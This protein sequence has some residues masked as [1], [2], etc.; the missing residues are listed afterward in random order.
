MGTRARSGTGAGARRILCSGC[1]S[2]CQRYVVSTAQP[3]FGQSRQTGSRPCADSADPN[4]QY[5]WPPQDPSR[6]PNPP[7][8]R[9][10]NAFIY[11]DGLNPNLRP[12]NGRRRQVQSEQRHEGADGWV[13]EDASGSGS[14]RGS[15]PER[16]LSDYDDENWGPRTAEETQEEQLR[17]LE[18]RVRRGS[19]GWEVRPAG[20]WNQVVGMRDGP[21]PAWLEQGR[22]NVYDPSDDVMSDSD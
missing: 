20:S 9:D 18:G 13:S 8:P 4:V 6:L 12:S 7:P 1:D 14:S 2:T 17:R 5:N 11:G 22:Y 15:S 19:E 21:G 10:G 16:Y 3:P